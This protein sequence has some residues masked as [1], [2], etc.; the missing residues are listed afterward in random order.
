MIVVVKWQEHNRAYT[1]GL[2]QFLKKLGVDVQNETIE[3]TVKK[4]LEQQELAEYEQP[5]HK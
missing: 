2:Q 3:L 1:I 4:L 5:E